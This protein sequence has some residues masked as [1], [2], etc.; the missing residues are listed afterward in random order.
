[1]KDTIYREDAIK[2][3]NTKPFVVGDAEAAINIYSYMCDV[4]RR[5]KNLPSAPPKRMRG[6]WI[7]RGGTINC[8]ICKHCNWSE[9][10]EHTVMNFNYCP[11]CG[12]DMRG[13]Q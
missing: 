5:L 2:A 8:S 10:F 6:K 11:N 9:C 12:A 3:F 4:M 1:M 13:K 7:K